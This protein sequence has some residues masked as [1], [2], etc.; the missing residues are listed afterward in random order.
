MF[1]VGD[2]AS[3][4]GT[5]ID[6]GIKKVIQQQYRARNIEWPVQGCPTQNSWNTWSKVPKESRIDSLGKL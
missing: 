2:N 6:H 1:T 4:Y 3:E 5:A